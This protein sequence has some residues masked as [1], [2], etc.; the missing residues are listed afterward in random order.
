MREFGGWF[1]L[2][3]EMLDKTDGLGIRT[4]RAASSVSREGDNWPAVDRAVRVASLQGK[5]EQLVLP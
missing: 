5:Q 3:E 1:D 2:T 4:V